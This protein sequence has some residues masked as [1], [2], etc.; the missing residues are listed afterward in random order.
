MVS[1]SAFSKEPTVFRAATV[2]ASAAW[3]AASDISSA[4]PPACFLASRKAR[5]K[6]VLEVSGI[7]IAPLELGV[8]GVNAQA[9]AK[10]QRQERL[11]VRGVLLSST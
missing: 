8:V 5:L 1:R 10:V 7:S 11:F 2:V 9:P 6:S 3:E 4:T